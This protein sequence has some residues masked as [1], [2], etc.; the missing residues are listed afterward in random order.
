MKITEYLGENQLMRERQSSYTY[1][2]YLRIL[3]AFMVIVVHVS[4]ANWF[5]IEIGSR[6]WIVQTFFNISGRFC[7]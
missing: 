5:D 4:G 7:V 6:D 3:C 2:E 1:M